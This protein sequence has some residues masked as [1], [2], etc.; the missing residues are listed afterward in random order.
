ME[1]SPSYEAASP[2]ATLEFSNILWNPNVHYHV[3][4]SPSLIPILG[5][6]D[7]VHTT[8]SYLSKT[9]PSGFPTD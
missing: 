4:K 9:L 7:Q 3:H 2:L 1:M 5:Q 8:L 6:I